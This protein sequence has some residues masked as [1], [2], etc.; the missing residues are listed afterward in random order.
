MN[1]DTKNLLELYERSKAGEFGSLGGWIECSL[2]DYLFNGV[3]TLDKAFC[4][5]GFN[6]TRKGNTK[7]SHNTRYEHILTAWEA[8]SNVESLKVWPRSGKL[9]QEARRFRANV[10]PR[11][12][13]LDELPCEQSDLRRALFLANKC[14]YV[15]ETQGGIHKVIK[16]MLPNCMNL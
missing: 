15:P 13:S 4:V 3:E 16:K 2:E 5:D 8:V 11:V 7:I 1:N 9:A 14:G 6:G 10:W 12:R